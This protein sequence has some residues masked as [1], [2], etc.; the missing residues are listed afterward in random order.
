[1][2]HNVTSTASTLLCANGK[3]VL[4]FTTFPVYILDSKVSPLAQE[5]RLVAVPLHL[6][7]KI[8]LTVII[9]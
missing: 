9:I 4:W 7:V 5:A 3:I 8:L 2:R 1:M 6:W